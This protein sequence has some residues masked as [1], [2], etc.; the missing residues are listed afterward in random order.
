MKELKKD[1]EYKEGNAA[2]IDIWQTA[3]QKLLP[4]KSL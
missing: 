3:I 4:Q 1:I 2:M